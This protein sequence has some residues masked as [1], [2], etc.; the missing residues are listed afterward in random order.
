MFNSSVS[1]F[2]YGLML[3]KKD[4]VTCMKPIGNDDK[5]LFLNS[6]GLALHRA[7]ARMR[8]HPEICFG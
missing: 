1:P 2:K 5:T 6:A 3:L 4:G 8:R 7:L